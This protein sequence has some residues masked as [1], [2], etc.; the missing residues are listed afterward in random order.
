MITFPLEFTYTALAAALLVPW[1]IL[2]VLVPDGRPMQVRISLFF[3]LFA[4]FEFLYTQDYW[5]APIHLAIPLLGGYAGLEDLIFAFAFGGVIAGVVGFA[6]DE[7]RWSGARAALI[8]TVAVY[9]VAIALWKLA[10]IESLVAASIAALLV[11][12]ASSATNLPNARRAVIGAAGALVTM[13]SVYFVGFLVAANTEAVLQQI[14]LLH[15][16]PLG[17][18]VLGVPL[19]E[20]I[21]AVAFGALVAIL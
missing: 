1:I 8:K 11:V 18:R 3:L 16:G 4:P 21:W 9:A 20:L 19:T 15:D 10:G 5:T 7:W 13:F 2:Y 17:T 14:W 6:L 12:S